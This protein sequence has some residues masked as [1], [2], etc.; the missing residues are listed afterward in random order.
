MQEYGLDSIARDAVCE[1]KYI[2]ES[3]GVSMKVLVA[4]LSTLLLAG[5]ALTADDAVRAKL[6]GKWEQSDGNGE[7][8]STWTLKELG[9]SMHVTN[10]SLTGTI[11]AFDCNI[12]GKECAIKH[13]GHKSKVALWFNGPKLI[14]METMGTQV[15][16]RRFTVTGDGDTMD[17][18][19][20][21]LVPGG[22]GE[23]TH[24]KRLGQESGKD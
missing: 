20:I 14:E 12:G 13:A 8:K 4:G 7:T 11:V 3:G 19:T 6:T 18:E 5:S 16:K 24:F 2:V 21:P 23:T 17:L 22:P 10:S 9:D 1:V 15:V